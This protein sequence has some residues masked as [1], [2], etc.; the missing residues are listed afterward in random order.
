MTSPQ[1]LT[2]AE[3]LAASRE[4]NN[5]AV[6]SAKVLFPKPPLPRWESLHLDNSIRLLS[7]ALA[8]NVIGFFCAWFYLASD[9]A[10][11]ML[12]PRYVILC[13]AI[14]FIVLIGLACRIQAVLHMAGLQKFGWIPVLV[15]GA[16]LGPMVIGWVVPARVL[17]G[18]LAARRRL[19]KAAECSQV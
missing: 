4:I 15:L 3:Q 18:A 5:A 10:P 7:A 1:G 14:D 2:L 11:L 13:L 6:D 9:A 8:L 19:R 16:I 12:E 17:S